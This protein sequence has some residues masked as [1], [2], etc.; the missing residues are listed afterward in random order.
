MKSTPAP[1]GP[2]ARC[3]CGSLKK[4]SRRLSRIYDSALAPVGIKYTQFAILAEIDRRQGREPA[5]ISELAGA[6]VM[7]R[8]TLG[9]N[10]RPLARDALVRLR[11]APDDHRRRCVELTKRGRAVLQKARQPWLRAEERFEAAFGRQASAALRQ[12]LRG[13]ASGERLRA[14]VTR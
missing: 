14:P 9:H 4:A 10:L 6:M 8:S 7:D 3:T 13:I 5:D 2:S 12:V 11:F 1:S